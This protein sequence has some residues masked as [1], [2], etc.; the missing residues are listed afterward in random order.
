MFWNDLGRNPD[1]AGKPGPPPPQQHPRQIV[2]QKSREKSEQ[3]RRQPRRRFAEAEEAIQDRGAPIRQRRLLKPNL[4][5]EQRHH[6]GIDRNRRGPF[7]RLEPHHSHRPLQHDRRDL[8][9]AGVPG[10]ADLGH[11]PRRLCNARFMAGGDVPRTQK[12]EKGERR[13]N[14]QPNQSP[15]PM[16]E[17]DGIGGSWR[18]REGIRVRDCREVHQSGRPVTDTQSLGRCGKSGEA[19]IV[20]LAVG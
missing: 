15:T 11:L 18:N 7:V 8:Y 16:H 19:C 1:Q 4:P 10:P 14:P 17:Q 5:F 9:P 20:R 12:W 2:N 3:R 13:Q 6:P